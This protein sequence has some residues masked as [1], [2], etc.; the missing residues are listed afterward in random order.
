MQ[1]LTYISFPLLVVLVG[2]VAAV[3]RTPGP[4]LTSAIQHLAAGVVFAAAA[5]EA[6]HS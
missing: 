3:L 2:A 6:S 4:V 5:A 1:A